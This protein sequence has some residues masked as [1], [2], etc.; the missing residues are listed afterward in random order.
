[1]TNFNNTQPVKNEEEVRQGET[2]RGMPVVLGISTIASAAL[3][4]AL[5]AGWS[6]V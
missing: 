1:M 3:L 5:V 6:F 2:K 4:L